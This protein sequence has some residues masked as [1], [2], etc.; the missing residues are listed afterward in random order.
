MAKLVAKFAGGAGHPMVRVYWDAAWGE[1]R[2]TVPG[3]RDATYLTGSYTDAIGTARNMA[4]PG[5]VDYIQAHG[6][7][8]GH[9]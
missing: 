9:D 5:W 3:N 2:V 4:G 6:P 8:P 7:K 1:Y